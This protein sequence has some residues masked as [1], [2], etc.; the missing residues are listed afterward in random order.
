M[1]VVIGLQS[2]GESN[3]GQA[4]ADAATQGEEMDD[5]VSA[6][7]VILRSLIAKQF[8]ITSTK[9]QLEADAERTRWEALYV[10]VY[11]I[12]R[13]WKQPPDGGANRG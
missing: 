2:T 7:A 6:P 10:H 11:A 9:S 1:A 4:M 5:F 8:P 3:V 12:V 13:R